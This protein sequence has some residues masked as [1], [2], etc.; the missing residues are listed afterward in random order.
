MELDWQVAYTA[1]SLR[2]VIHDDFSRI[3]TIL[4]CI[5]A[6]K[7]ANNFRK[8]WQRVGSSEAAVVLR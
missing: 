5:K 7:S 4:N 6:R 8:Y 2:K 1:P 3:A